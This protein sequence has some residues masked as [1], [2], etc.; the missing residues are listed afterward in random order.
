MMW[1]YRSLLLLLPPSFRRA[2]GHELLQVA[3][4]ALS[5]DRAS[6][7]ALTLDLLRSIFRE[8]HDAFR[9]VA[10]RLRVPRVSSVT[11]DIRYAGRSLVKSPGSTIAAVITLA[12][13]IGANT[14]MLT[15]ADS[16]LLRPVDVAH[17][18]RLVSWTWTS[19]YPDYVRYTA[20]HDIFSGV[21]G[22]SGGSRISVV[23]DGPAEL[24]SA[25]FLSGN[26]FDV[27]GITPA[28]G[29][30]MV[31]ADDIRNAPIVGVL[32]HDFWQS[33]F[34]G[35]PTVVGRLVRI[36][37]HAVTIVGV[38][39]AGFRGLSLGSRPSI[40]LP[41]QASGPVRGG[42]FNQPDLLN[43]RN[44]V[45]LNVVGRLRD[46]VTID[47]A[48]A[49][50]DTL[51]RQLHPPEPGR[52][53]AP[54]KLTGLRTRALGDDESAIERFVLLLVGVVALT[55]MIG[56]ANLASLLLARTTSR[57]HE[58]G[59]R[60]AIGAQRGDVV[61][62]LL[63]ESLVLAGLGG[64]AG[65]VVA[66]ATLQ[67]L[68]AYQL[69]GGL[70]INTLGLALDR[71]SLAAALI[72]TLITGIVFGSAPAWHAARTDVLVTL[73]D[74]TRRAAGST[75]M[76]SALVAAQVAVSL[77]LLTGSGLFLRSLMHA[78]AL[79]TGFDTSGVATASVN[80]GL[81]RYDEGRARSY[82]EAAL[83]RVQQ[84]PNV[85]A[86][87][88]ASMIPTNG[89][90]MNEVDIEGFQPRGEARPTFYMSEVGPGYFAA[91]G[92]R[93]VEG[94]AF[95]DGDRQ[96]APLV[97]IVSRTAATKYWPHG[98]AIGGQ[99]KAG[100]S[101]WR[102]VVGVTEDVT[103]R[104]LGESPVPFAFYPFDQPSGQLRRPTDPAHLFV[105][106]AG[107][108]DEAV[109]QLAA[110]LRTVDSAMPVYDVVPFAQHV[111]ELVMPQRMGAT[112]F[113]LFSVLAVSLAAVGLFGVAS[114]VAQLQTRELGIRIALG[115]DTSAVQRHVLARGVMP[116]LAGVAAGLG[117]ASWLARF[118]SGFLYDISPT[119]PV[120]LAAAAGLLVAIALAAAW[121][122]A[123]RA[124][125]LD[126]IAAL[127]VQ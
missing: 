42:F 29:R 63:V 34:G 70:G 95:A 120:V 79:P 51:Y 17:P 126:P 108:S 103:V 113:A 22:W 19:A 3:R 55:L 14:A 52:T 97:A 58:V 25:T 114:Y 96:G 94:R 27:L 82:H 78:L 49:A 43:S 105:R 121:L 13:S 39:R 112:L 76:R 35:D 119:D 122:P 60:M 20:Q 87:A 118:A 21:V 91:A 100:G 98:T 69:P 71:S 67:L 104:E 84:L 89:L 41:L 53:V 18:E 72:L 26:A 11:R 109:G 16:T 4:T 23:V 44:W 117:L 125:R 68:S 10:E 127:R 54:L 80:P 65:I 2:H 36:N 115:A 61:R 45:W 48:S 59:V 81:L 107:E 33:R 64:L 111:R 124:A 99:I 46:S 86:A 9:A 101:A 74:D 12:L 85:K 73:R 110:Q 30:V 40:Y 1:L 15:L 88:W 8:W 24:A 102:T 47:Q 62:Q 116:A 75:R 93:V 77:V 56:C 50:V 6:R 5:R 32:S 37:G 123:R 83:A 28:T 38:A 31:A 90:M 106:F 7:V 57:R 92:T 66:S